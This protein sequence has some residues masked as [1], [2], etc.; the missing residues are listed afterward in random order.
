MPFQEKEAEKKEGGPSG[1]VSK[2]KEGPGSMMRR[3]LDVLLLVFL[4]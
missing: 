1:G 2:H 3:F 4:Q